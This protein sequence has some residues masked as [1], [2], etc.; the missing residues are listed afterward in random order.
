MRIDGGACTALTRPRALVRSGG[1]WSRWRPGPAG[2]RLTAEEAS[3][4]PSGAGLVARKG[5]WMWSDQIASRSRECETAPSSG[6]HLPGAKLPGH[7]ES[8]HRVSC[9]AP[10]LVVGVIDLLATSDSPSQGGGQGQ[11]VDSEPP[12]QLRDC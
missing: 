9:R 10:V 7:F 12:G 6:G 2:A 11:K 1:R 3:K 5:L 8:H 4:A